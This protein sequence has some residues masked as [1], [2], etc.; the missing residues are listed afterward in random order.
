MQD[1]PEDKAKFKREYLQ[2]HRLERMVDVVYAIIIWRAFIL[3]PRPT[4]DQFSWEHIGAFLCA[5]IGVFLLVIIGIVVTIIYWIQNNVLFGNL[6]TTDSRHTI[7]SILQL[8]FLL[9]FLVSMR[10]GIELGA[11]NATR[12]LESIAAA[13]VGIAGGWGW[14][15]AIKNHR[16][17]LPEVTEQYAY[18]LRDRILAEPITAIITIPFAFAGPILW[19]VSWLSYLLVVILV[20]RQRRRKIA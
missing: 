8:F 11:S 14:S 4:A 10:L 7:L 9:V 16:L 1:K 6:Q 2:L 13:L 17:L 5:N 20:R 18:R 15:Y 3:L 19:E 12:V